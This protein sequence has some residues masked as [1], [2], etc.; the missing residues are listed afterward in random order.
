MKFRKLP[1]ILMNNLLRWDRIY[2]YN[3]SCDCGFV[4]KT[5]SDGKT[6]VKI[7]I[8]TSSGQWFYNQLLCSKLKSNSAV[9]DVCYTDDY[10]VMRVR[11][12]DKYGSESVAGFYNLDNSDTC[13]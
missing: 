7:G 6:K 2:S 10:Y 3:N 4:E 5:N 1:L 9:A 13:E 8:K 12:N 11:S